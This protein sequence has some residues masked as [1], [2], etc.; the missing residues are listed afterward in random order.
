M[1]WLIKIVK[2]W[3]E[4]RIDLRL[5]KFWGDYMFFYVNFIDYVLS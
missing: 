5:K 3:E 2:K 4:K 1:I